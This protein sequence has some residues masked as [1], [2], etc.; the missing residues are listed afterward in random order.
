MFEYLIV[1]LLV[2][3]IGASYVP[4]LKSVWLLMLIGFFYI[5]K[6]TY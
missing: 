6:K 3:I 5:Q 1:W 4:F 2:G